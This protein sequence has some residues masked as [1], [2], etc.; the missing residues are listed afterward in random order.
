MF[1]ILGVIWSTIILVVAIAAV[2]YEPYPAISD[3]F[4]ATSKIWYKTRVPPGQ[5]A[6]FEQSM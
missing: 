2:G 4:N 5:M 3:S 6:S 1:I